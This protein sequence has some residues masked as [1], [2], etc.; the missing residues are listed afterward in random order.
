MEFAYIL[1]IYVVYK[2]GANRIETLIGT[3]SSWQRS[4]KLANLGLK[5]ER[6]IFFF[7][8]GGKQKNRLDVNGKKCSYAN[9]TINSVL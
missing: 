1:Y 6:T 5:G 7:P 3:I 9:G 2:V 8:H 4:K